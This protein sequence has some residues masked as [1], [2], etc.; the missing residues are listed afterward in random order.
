MK[1]TV[2]TDV[3]QVTVYLPVNAINKFKLAA[4]DCH[5]ELGP[6]SPLVGFILSKNVRTKPMESTK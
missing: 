2:L 5:Q 6:D 4:R 3:P 1:D